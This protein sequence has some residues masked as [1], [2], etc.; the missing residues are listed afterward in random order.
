M[1]LGGEAGAGVVA[2][3]GLRLSQWLAQG[4]LTCVAA[5]VGGTPVPGSPAPVKMQEVEVAVAGLLLL[6]SPNMCYLR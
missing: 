1:P 6:F 4:L 3:C 2:L 5:T